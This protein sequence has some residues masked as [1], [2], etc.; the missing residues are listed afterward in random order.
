MKKASKISEKISANIP[1]PVFK[2]AKALA[3]IYG[4]TMSDLI[5][6]L[7]EN[8]VA[9]NKD[10]IEDFQSAQDAAQHKCS[11]DIPL[12]KPIPAK[13]LNPPCQKTCADAPLERSW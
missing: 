4:L 1:V 10:A 13:S 8:A 3:A 6:T 11:F 7:L 5:S 2:R 12:N 9:K